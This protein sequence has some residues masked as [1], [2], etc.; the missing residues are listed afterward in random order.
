MQTTKTLIKLG[1]CPVWSESSMGAHSF[2]WF[3]HDA[4]Q[5]CFMEKYGKLSL[6][7]HQIPTI[8]VSLSSSFSPTVSWSFF[9]TEKKTLRKSTAARSEQ[10]AQ[11][12]KDR[13]A[14]TKMLKEIAT[15]KRV[16]EVRRLTQEEL[17]EEAKITEELNL[18]SL[19]TVKIKK[20]RTPEKL[21]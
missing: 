13:E 17:L 5:L 4:A 9:L 16:S 10:I 2:C 12:E 8:S 7:Y 14:R 11:R 21:L 19:G 3:C 6:N 20:I 15:Q 1:G 18:M